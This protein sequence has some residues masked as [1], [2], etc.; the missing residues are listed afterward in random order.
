MTPREK[1]LAAAILAL[2]CLWGGWRGWISY[3]EGYDQRVAEFSRLDN[4]LFD[5]QMEAKRARRALQRLERFQQQS[6]PADPEVARSVY[7]AWLVETV[8]SAG[9]ELGSVKWAST[10]RYED[11]ATALTFGVNASGSPEAVARWL[12]AYYRLDALHQLANL[13]VRPANA[14]GDVW[15]IALTSNALIIDGAQRERGLPEGPPE[16]TRLRLATSDAY[17]ESLAGRNVFASYTPPPP[18]R[19]DPPKVVSE[20][21]PTKAKP[22]AFDDAEHAQLTGIVETGA[23]L[24]AWVRIR[25]TGE[26]LRLQAGDT[27]EVGLMK[28]T[29]QAVLPKAMVIEGEDGVI[30][31]APL[32]SK[33]REAQAKAATERG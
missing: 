18:P 19:V 20:A 2:I 23:E 3:T 1:N 32:G 5:Q 16:S 10:R 9:L 8:K 4:D 28:G 7:S 17:A 30:W 6:L 33:L 22:P 29:V 25:T 12:D 21:R 13:Q 14:S 15:S 24:E 26:T 31:R 11:A 27:L